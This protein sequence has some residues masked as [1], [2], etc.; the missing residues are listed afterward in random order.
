MVSTNRPATASRA[1]T[2]GWVAVHWPLSATMAEDDRMKTKL[3][4]RTTRS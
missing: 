3:T 1:S 2:A 4:I